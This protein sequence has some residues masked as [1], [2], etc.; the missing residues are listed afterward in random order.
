[1]SHYTQH[2][3]AALVQWPQ[4]VI[5]IQEALSTTASDAIEFDK[6]KILEKKCITFTAAAGGPD[7]FKDL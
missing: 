1:M 5:P 7:I 4:V 3:K 2:L 6:T